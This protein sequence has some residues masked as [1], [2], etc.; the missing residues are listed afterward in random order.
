MDDTSNG[1][2]LDN[3][4]NSVFPPEMA[5]QSTPPATPTEHKT[6]DPPA[7][8]PPTGGRE[9]GRCNNSLTAGTAGDTMKRRERSSMVDGGGAKR[10]KL[11]FEQEQQGLSAGNSNGSMRLPGGVDL[12]SFLD[13]IHSKN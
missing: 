3:L 7:I 4:I 8:I 6:S 1:N 11:N 10:P 5:S 2:W 13:H 9:R 12:E